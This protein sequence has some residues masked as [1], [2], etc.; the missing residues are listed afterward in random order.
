M[1]MIPLVDMHCHLLAGLD[2]GPRTDEE[3]V[4]MCRLA[5]ADG[6]RT[7]AALAD[8]NERWHEVKADV[9]R[10]RTTHLAN[11]LRQAGIPLAVFPS[12]EVMVQPRLL[13]AWRGGELLSVADRKGYILLEM[14]HG[15]EV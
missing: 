2:D 4:E 15:V 1:P 5:F 7:S 9:I 13:E 10:E 11:R 3:A 8:Q 14:P 6:I 12:A